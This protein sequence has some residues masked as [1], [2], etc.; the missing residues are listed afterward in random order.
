MKLIAQFVFYI[1]AATFASN[2]W[3]QDADEADILR[4]EWVLHDG[5]ESRDVGHLH[6]A[7]NESYPAIL[8][9][10]ELSELPVI[11]VQ[12]WRDETNYQDAMEGALGS[13]APGSRGYIT[14]PQDVRL[15]Y[16]TMLSA[17]KEAVHEFVHAAT[18]TLNPEFGNNPRWLWE[19]A[20]QYLAGEFVDPK[21]GNLFA[22][23][24]CPS[25]ETLNSPF[26]RGGAIYRS[27]YLLG[28]YVVQTWG[29]AALP[30]LIRLN[31]DT[32]AAFD[33]SI[34]SFESQWCAYVQ[35]RYMQ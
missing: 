27:G 25:L 8:N 29:R 12:V 4:F 19:A 1:T 30:E 34:E 32:G 33:Q 6:V 2:S 31:G 28:D 10:L 15:L 35:T 14:G 17:Q 23:G 5:L 20:A 21:T 24:Q 9:A 13:R 3:T 18:L 16:H 22:D 7:L 26:D 11:K